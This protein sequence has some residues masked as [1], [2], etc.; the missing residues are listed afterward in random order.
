LLYWFDISTGKQYVGNQRVVGLSTYQ[1]DAALP[2]RTTLPVPV[3]LPEDYRPQALIPDARLVAE[4]APTRLAKFLPDWVWD[5]ERGPYELLTYDGEDAGTRRSIPVQRRGFVD[6]IEVHDQEP[7]DAGEWL[8]TAIVDGEVHYFRSL[9]AGIELTKS[10]SLED[11]EVIVQ[12]RWQNAGD[13]RT[14]VTWCSLAELTPDYAAVLLKGRKVLQFA[15][16]LERPAVR[17]TAAK[18]EVQIVADPPAGDVQCEE[19]LLALELLL[20]YE[21]ELEAG[22]EQRVRFRMRRAT[23]KQRESSES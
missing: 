10:Y 14:A 15:H 20:K 12:Y 19:G 18:E 8:A 9:P 7:E 17:N 6:Y 2:E 21:I 3:K 23:A 13:E 16:D 11:G 1:G 5:E 4:A 22:A